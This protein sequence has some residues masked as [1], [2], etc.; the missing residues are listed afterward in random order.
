VGLGCDVVMWLGF[1]L[2]PSEESGGACTR[3]GWPSSVIVDVGAV[4]E[5]CVPRSDT[6]NPCVMYLVL[7]SQAT[8]PSG[9]PMLPNCLL[10]GLDVMKGG[11]RG[12][13]VFG[14]VFTVVESSTRGEGEGV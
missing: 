13:R 6:P 8:L 12:L 10:V 7:L 11:I 3:A 14:S 1:L 2:F 4:A 9:S 5:G